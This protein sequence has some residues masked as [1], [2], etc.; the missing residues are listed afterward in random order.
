MSV[1][2]TSFSNVS[3][4]LVLASV[5]YSSI[6]AFSDSTKGPNGAISLGDRLLSIV[7]DTG[8][9]ILDFRALIMHP[10][11]TCAVLRRG[12]VSLG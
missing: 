7:G 8:D 4:L 10:S 12:L 5:L 11:V 1:T 9:A 2:N 6:W 3:S